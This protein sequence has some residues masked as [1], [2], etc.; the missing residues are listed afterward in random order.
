MNK[1]LV[2]AQTLENVRKLAKEQGNCVSEEQVRDAFSELELDD[3]QLQMVFDYLIKHK[4]GIG[5]PVD[6]DDFLSDK[7]KDYLKDYL[8]EIEALPVHSSGE[9]MAFTISAMAGESDAQ[10]KLVEAHLK[11]VTEIAKLYAGQGV[12][13]ED[14]IGE[15]NVAL[16]MGCTMLGSLERPEEAE[17]ML[18]KM[19]MDAMEDYISEHLAE[20][21]KDKKVADKVNK[22]LEQAK[23]LS[24]ELQRK[25]TVEELS[26][27]TGMSQKS[28]EEAIKMSGNKIEYIE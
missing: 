19:I 21:K 24:E 1:E 26:N 18:G 10:N 22:V 4:V 25:V 28:I 2:F 7:E 13:L 6:P 3:N 17:G 12:Y 9:I 15:G 20:E 14:L 27:E 8:D 23:N 16:A 11:D 5:Q